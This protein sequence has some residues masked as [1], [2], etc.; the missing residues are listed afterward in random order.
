MR[1]ELLKTYEESLKEGTHVP[2]LVP[3][4][5]RRK[6]VVGEVR[7]VWSVPVERFLIIRPLDNGLYLT[8][9]MS[10]YLL[11]LP[12][13]SPF[14][15]LTASGLRLGVVPTWDYLR[16]EFIEKH[17]SPI[18]KIPMGDLQRIEHWIKSWREDGKGV[19]YG[20]RKF[21]SLNARYWAKWT[22]ASLLHHADLAEEE[23]EEA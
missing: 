11:L 5:K 9:P 16:E 13:D 4:A 10:A 6:P 19:D 15:R 2:A 7:E 17:S 20:V 12:P 18:G 22:M 1:F 3:E 23:E 8:A 21:I 14:Y